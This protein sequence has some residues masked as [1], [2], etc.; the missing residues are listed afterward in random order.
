MRYESDRARGAV[1]D[2]LCQITVDAVAG[3]EVAASLGNAD[4][5]HVRVQLGR[6]QTIVHEA[7]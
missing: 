2:A 5:R 7:L 4:N 3:C 6:C 1:A